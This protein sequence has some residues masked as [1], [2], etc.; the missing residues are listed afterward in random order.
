MIQSSMIKGTSRS[1][2]LRI[3]WQDASEDWAALWTIY[4]IGREQVPI[5]YKMPLTEAM[6]HLHEQLG[7]VE[8]E[9][10]DVAS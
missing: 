8:M 2:D 4:D 6:R 1:M 7:G 9:E 3:E 5:V 10:E